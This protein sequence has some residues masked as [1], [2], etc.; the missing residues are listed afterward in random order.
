MALLT[1]CSN[2]TI[3]TGEG[4]PLAKESEAFNAASAWVEFEN[5]FRLFY[6]YLE[7]D[8]LDSEAWFKDVQLQA[9]QTKT[10]AEFRDVIR[11]AAYLFCD[12]HIVIG[13]LEDNGLNVFPTS[14]DLIAELVSGEYVITHVR[15]G[16]PAAASDIRPGWKITEIDGQSPEA[17]LEGVLRGFS[18]DISETQKAYLITLGLNGRRTGGRGLKFTHEGQIRT[19]QL[20]SARDFARSLS[21]QPIVSV[22]TQG[23]TAIIRINNALGNND[24]IQDFDKALESVKDKPSLV[25]DLRNTP[26]GG[27]TEVGRSLIGHFI[28][29]E[30]PYQIHEIPS[31]EREF[32]VPRKFIELVQPREPYFPPENLRVLSG[33]WTGS[34]GEGITIGLDAAADATIIASDMGDMLGGLSNRYLKGSD[35]K[36]DLATEVL[37]HVNG[38]PREDFIADI[39]PATVELGPNGE[40]IGLRLAIGSF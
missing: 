24:L 20:E 39:A 7:T 38:T 9:E 2:P 15:L 17:F 14:S 23:D 40:D 18:L 26:S 11:R 29:T 34:M 5:T 32:T 31:L 10:A 8:V 27:N 12:P 1:A 6:A 36:L 30:Q 35:M 19:V 37:T 33:P 13:P 28:K 16:S 4:T 25:L 3:K 21:K 22:K